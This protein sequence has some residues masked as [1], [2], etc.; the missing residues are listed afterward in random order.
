M[1]DAFPGVSAK[2]TGHCDQYDIGCLKECPYGEHGNQVMSAEFSDAAV[3]H[4]R[5]TGD[6]QAKAD[7]REAVVARH[8]ANCQCSREEQVH[9][10]W[11]SAFETNFCKLLES[12]KISN[13]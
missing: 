13:S 3:S 5:V 11:N 9:N 6:F 1:F 10:F 4:Q 7:K 12:A 8:H 2:E